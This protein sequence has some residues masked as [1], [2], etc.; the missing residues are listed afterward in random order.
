MNLL[1]AVTLAAAPAWDAARCLAW[2]AAEHAAADR[3]T[4]HETAPHARAIASDDECGSFLD[5]A[6][7]LREELR[8]ERATAPLEH[9]RP[10]ARSRPM[11]VEGGRIGPVSPFL[12][13]SAPRSF[14]AV[15]RI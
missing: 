15:L 4:C 8:Q 14:A 2:C 9:A 3:A 11:T 10:I 5:G 6:L 7:F 13:D 12:S 1:V